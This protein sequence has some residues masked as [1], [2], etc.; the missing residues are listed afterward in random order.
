MR[1]I[2]TD[3]FF[4]Q[5]HFCIFKAITSPW[6]SSRKLGAAKVNLVDALL[7]TVLPR[8]LNAANNSG[9]A[10]LPFSLASRRRM[11]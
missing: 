2:A 8:N 6:D 4:L 3:P 10:N 11:V 1:A 7:T 9:L 5:A